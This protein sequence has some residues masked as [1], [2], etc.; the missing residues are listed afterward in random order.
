[1]WIILSWGVNKVIQ[2]TAIID[3]AYLKHLDVYISYHC[4]L[5]KR[6]DEVSSDIGIS[7]ER[8]ETT[9]LDENG[10]LKLSQPVKNQKMSQEITKV[11]VTSCKLK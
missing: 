11:E 8:R 3:F 6:T 2:I 10:D 7:Q 9:L 1:M 5:G 4:V